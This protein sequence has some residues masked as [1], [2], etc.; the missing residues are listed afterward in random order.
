MILDPSEF[1]LQNLKEEQPAETGKILL[2]GSRS[3]ILEDL[4]S[5]FKDLQVRLIFL[6]LSMLY[7]PM[8]KEIREESYGEILRKTSDN[9]KK[10]VNTQTIDFTEEMCVKTVYLLK[11]CKLVLEKEG[12]LAIKVNGTIKSIIKSRLDNIFGIERFV[13]EIIVDSPF[14]LWYDPSSAV[15]DRTDYIL[16]YCQNLVPQI[17]PVFNE[18]VSGGYWH[19]FVSKG[20]GSPKKFIF[21]ETGEVV[22]D[23]PPGTH[24]KLKQETILD[25]CQKGKI[26]LNLLIKYYS[27]CLK[28]R[29][30]ELAEARECLF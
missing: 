16:L 11:N 13:N 25:L 2:F 14:K 21:Q 4:R 8:K 19:S 12:F 22:L 15:F 23:P 10:T 7:L 30:V 3:T 1:I 17:N 24:W 6:D 5:Y 9:L 26:R 28:Y 18:K 27:V 20:Q 29:A